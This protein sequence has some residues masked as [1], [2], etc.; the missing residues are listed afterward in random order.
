MLYVR[1]RKALLPK[2][3][4]FVKSESCGFFKLVAAARQAFFA[5]S[6][7]Q[8]C[9]ETCFDIFKGESS[10]ANFVLRMAETTSVSPNAYIYDVDGSE[11]LE[12]SASVSQKR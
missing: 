12:S 9:R 3:L 6:A 10:R 5:R 1:P 8:H 2:I 11:N 7:F 4:S